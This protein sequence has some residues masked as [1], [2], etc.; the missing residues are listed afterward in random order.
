MRILYVYKNNKTKERMK[1]NL[2]IEDKDLKSFLY[3]MEYFCK[4]QDWYCF[5][6]EDDICMELLGEKFNFIITEGEVSERNKKN[7]DT[8]IRPMMRIMGIFGEVL[9]DRRFD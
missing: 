7:F 4:Y 3:G 5:L 6:K 9:I 8:I 2:G 1:R